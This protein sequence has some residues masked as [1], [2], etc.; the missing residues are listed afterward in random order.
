MLL[1]FVHIQYNEVKR[2]NVNDNVTTTVACVLLS[3]YSHKI[4]VIL[5]RKHLHEL[6]A[7]EKKSV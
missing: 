7:L 4:T 5:Y 3:F 6:I 2:F 1:K